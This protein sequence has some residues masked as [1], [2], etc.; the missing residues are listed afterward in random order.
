MARIPQS[1]IDQLLD[2]TDIVSIIDLRVSLKKTGR[3]Y[4]EIIKK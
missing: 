4:K 1:F 2:R 3:E